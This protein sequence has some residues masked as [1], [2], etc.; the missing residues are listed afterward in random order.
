MTQFCFM[1]MRA[2]PVHGRHRS[3][4][5]FGISTV[6]TRIIIYL[7]TLSLP[8]AIECSLYSKKGVEVFKQFINAKDEVF[9]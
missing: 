2:I 8:Y 7:N 9:L 1:T 3:K 6:F 5:D 4:V